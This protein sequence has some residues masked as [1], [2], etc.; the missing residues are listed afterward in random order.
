MGNWWQR[1][2]SDSE[3]LVAKQTACRNFSQSQISCLLVR[4]GGL[5]PAVGDGECS[6]LL[7]AQLEIG[8]GVVVTLFK[9]HD[10]CVRVVYGSCVARSMQLPDILHTPR[11]VKRR[12]SLGVATFRG[13]V[14]KDCDARRNGADDRRYRTIRIAVMRNKIGI[15]MPEQVNRTREGSQLRSSQISQ[16]EEGE[17]AE[18]ETNAKRSRVFSFFSRGNCRRR[19]CG[20]RCP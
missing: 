8:A 18:A 13:A 7:G 20:I 1:A 3:I 14:V 12:K 9:I 5:R 2:I 17:L 15:G 6:A 4:L 16:V 19:A 11:V 10:E